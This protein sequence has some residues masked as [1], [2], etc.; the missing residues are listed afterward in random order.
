M[1]RNESA[2]HERGTEKLD[3]TRSLQQG[4]DKYQQ[5]PVQRK[6]INVKSSN[7]RNKHKFQPKQQNV[8]SGPPSFQIGLVG[9]VQTAIDV[10]LRA[11]RS[12]LTSLM[13]NYQVNFLNYKT[14]PT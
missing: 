4:T 10:D 9:S 2:P 8:K 11:Y 12:Q 13:Q 7:K 5:N 1:P 3:Q 14:V 6:E